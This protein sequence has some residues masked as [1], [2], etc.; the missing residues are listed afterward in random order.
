MALLLLAYLWFK[1]VARQLV[2]P[3]AVA[4]NPPWWRPWRLPTA[5]G[6]P[7]GSTRTSDPAPSVPGRTTAA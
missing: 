4:T 6:E 7:Q 5:I 1:M 3:D 2:P